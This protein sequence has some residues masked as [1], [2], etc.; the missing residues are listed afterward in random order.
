MNRRTFGDMMRGKQQDLGD[1]D[2]DEGEEE[3]GG[4]GQ[5]R[6]ERRRQREVEG[7]EADGAEK[8]NDAGVVIE[9]FNM[10]NERE[11]G[12][13][14]G[15]MNYVF[16]KDEGDPD[17]WLAGLDE[18]AEEQAIDE[19]AQAAKNRRVQKRKKEMQA[20]RDEGLARDPRDLKLA[21]VRILEENESIATA[22]KRL[23]MESSAATNGSSSARSKRDTSSVDAL[24]DLVSEL[25]AKGEPLSY[26]VTKEQ[27]ENSVVKWEYMAL[28][29]SLQG[30]FSTEIMAQWHVAG[31]FSAA[32]AVYMRKVFPVI[33]S[34]GDASSAACTAAESGH[35][36]KR[37]RI[38]DLEND[39][40][41]D[42]DSDDG[43][44]TTKSDA[45]AASESSNETLAESGSEK[46][47][48][49]SSN[50]V[51]FGL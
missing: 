13:I 29:G 14:D 24:T 47:P 23:A 50:D 32:N 15:Q 19:A 17:S 35:V 5:G 39:F 12:R 38:A 28:D 9:P 27:L 16:E 3:E 7:E 20:A 18:A 33:P 1:D 2:S 40:D 34:M 45:P 11:S 22:M 37:A 49:I 36:S 41:S 26:T 44:N 8:F 21:I 43:K 31:C 6:G 46:G 25:L 42:N 48:W 10:K 4:P 51:D 30:P